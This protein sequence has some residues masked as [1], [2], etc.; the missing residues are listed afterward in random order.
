MNLFNNVRLYIALL[1]CMALYH[2]EMLCSFAS[3]ELLHVHYQF[4][5]AN[6]ARLYACVVLSLY[7]T[8]YL[9]SVHH[10]TSSRYISADV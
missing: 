10:H 2:G 8:C 1:T 6:S 3:V 7:S 5:P 4:K 9:L